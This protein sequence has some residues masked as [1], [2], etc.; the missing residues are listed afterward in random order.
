VLAELLAYTENHFQPDH[1]PATVVLPLE[2]E[3]HV[4][5]WREYAAAVEAGGSIEPLRDVFVQLRFPIRAGISQ[6]ETYRSATRLGVDPG[7]QPDAVRLRGPVRLVLHEH[8]AGPVPAFITSD[9]DDFVALF[10]VFTERNEPAPVPDSQGAVVVAGF[11]NWDR[12]RR[13]GGDW[14]VLEKAQYQDHFLIVSDGPY[15][16]V[17]ASDIGLQDDDW[18]ARSVTLRLEHE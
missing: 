11:N 13:S 16:R 4:A 10:R 3:R 15:S 17:R 1:L 12:I 7:T 2:P 18:R 9:R 14:S 6:D 5:V 8:A